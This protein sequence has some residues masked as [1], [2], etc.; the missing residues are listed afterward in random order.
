MTKIPLFWINPLWPI[1]LMVQKSG[2]KTT[3][4][5]FEAI[6]KSWDIYHINWLA[7]FLPSTVCVFGCSPL[8]SASNLGSQN[9]KME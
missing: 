1:L 6:K 5:V 3:W 2:E 8:E 4:D 7:R 9:L